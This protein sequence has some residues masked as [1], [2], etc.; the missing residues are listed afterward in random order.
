MAIMNIMDDI[1]STL[2]AFQ[3]ERT[4]I[5][6]SLHSKREKNKILVAKYASYQTRLAKSRE[7]YRESFNDFEIARRVADKQLFEQE[8]KEDEEKVCQFQLQVA[9]DESSQASRLCENH[10]QDFEHKAAAIADQ[11]NGLRLQ[12]DKSRV[13]NKTNEL[14][15]DFNTGA[16][17]EATKRTNSLRSKLT[18]KT[19]VK[20]C[21]EDFY[22]PG[23]QS[24][25]LQLLK[26]DLDALKDER[27]QIRSTVRDYDKH[28]NNVREQLSTQEVKGQRLKAKLK[29]LQT[30]EK[31]LESMGSS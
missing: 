28:R 23:A 24:K 13:E 11:L 17:H 15:K 20:A 22:P 26:R 7:E 19:D 12:H 3:Q 6:K 8:M 21:R 31:A 30:E 9:A 4:K 18:Y 27:D 10:L 1:Q 29:A 2:K 16:L 5:Q 14:M 25:L